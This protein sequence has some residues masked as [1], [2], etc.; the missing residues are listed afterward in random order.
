MASVVTGPKFAVFSKSFCWLSFGLIFPAPQAGQ[1]QKR[2]GKS[3]PEENRSRGPVRVYLF[4]AKWKSESWSEENQ[5]RDLK[6]IEAVVLFVFTFSGLSGNRSRGLKK[7]KA[8][9]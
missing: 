2:I 7:I 6:K 8:V 4:G 5:S 9:V 1:W 3:E